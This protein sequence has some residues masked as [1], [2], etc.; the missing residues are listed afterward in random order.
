MGGGRR[1][2]K[3]KGSLMRGDMLEELGSLDGGRGTRVLGGL[4]GGLEE[5]VPLEKGGPWGW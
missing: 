5:R 2:V 1:G 4:R 3:E